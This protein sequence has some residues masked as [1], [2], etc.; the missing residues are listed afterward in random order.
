MLILSTALQLVSAGLGFGEGRDLDAIATG[1]A[2]DRD[3]AVE[4]VDPGSLE[5]FRE[6]AEAIATEIPAEVS[7]LAA[8]AREHLRLRLADE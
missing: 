3:A 1:I 2:R 4:R 5:G 7:N 8:E 6:R